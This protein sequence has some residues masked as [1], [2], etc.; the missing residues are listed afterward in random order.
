MKHLVRLAVVSLL[1]V[2]CSLPSGVLYRCETNGTC[3]QAGFVCGADQYCHPAQTAVDAGDSPDAGGPDAGVVDAGAPDAGLCG[4]V[5]CF[6]FEDGAG[7]T[8]TDSTGH[9]PGTL[10]NSPVWTTGRFGSGLAFDGANNDV[11]LG[12]GPT[13]HLTGSM[14]IAAWIFVTGA[15]AGGDDAAIVSKRQSTSGFQLDTTIDRG[16]RTIGFKLQDPSDA[17]MIRYGQTPVSEGVWHHVVGVYDATQ[18]TMDVYLDGAA[19]NGELLGQVAGA[20]ND[21]VASVTLGSRSGSPGGY[22]FNGVIDE[23]MIFDRALTATE[24]RALH[25]AA[26]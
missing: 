16:P 18:R 19:D 14:T 9:N 22:N 20:Q 24:V 10:R 3:A 17:P 2:G 11:D 23:V 6:H 13:L 7:T 15:P 4:N 8:L 25:R 5:A 12:N 26:P 1:G 21:P